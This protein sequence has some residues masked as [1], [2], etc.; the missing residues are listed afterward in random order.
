MCASCNSYGHGRC[1]VDIN[2]ADSKDDLPVVEESDICDR[3]N[4]K[5]ET[6][7]LSQGEIDMLIMGW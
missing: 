5:F 3:W 7:L 2:E 1:G 4:K 6:S